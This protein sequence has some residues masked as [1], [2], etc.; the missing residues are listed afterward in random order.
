M[1]SKLLIYFFP[2]VLVMFLIYG[3]STQDSPDRDQAANVIATNT[4]EQFNSTIGT[5]PLDASSAVLYSQ[6]ELISNPGGGF[7]GANASAITDPGT[8]FGFGNQLLNGN[9]MADDFTVPAGET[10]IIDSIIVFHYQTGSTTTSTI[11]N[12][13]LRIW[14]G[15]TPGTGTV[16]AGDS[17]TN[18][19]G[20]SYFSG[21]YRVTATTLTNNQRPIMRSQV[22]MNGA[23]LTG[24]T[25]W[26]DYVAGGTLASGP[27]NPPRTIPGQPVTG[28]AYQRLGTTF[29]WAPALDG[30][31]PQG[32]P[33]VIYG[34]VS[35]PPVGGNTLVLM[36]DS[37]ASTTQ[38]T[39][40]RD[41]LRRYLQ[42]FV[43]NYTVA[44]FTATSNLP[45]LTPY[46]TIILQETSFDAAAVRYL[47]PAG[48]AA[49]KAW[50]ASGTASS[51]KSLISIGADQ[52]YNYSRVGSP[53]IDLEFSDTYGKYIFRVD[54]APGATLPS[55]TGVTIDIGNMRNL[56][57][58]PPG[59]SYWPDGCSMSSGG[60]SLYKYQNRSAADT[61]AAIGNNATG[62][63]VATLFCD[64]RYFTGG[65]KD[66][67]GSIVGWVRANGG[68]ITG[69]GNTVAVNIPNEY[70]L[71]QNY[72]NPFNPT[73]KIDYTIPKSGFVSLKI[74]DMLG[75][76]VM[77]LVNGVIDAGSHQA[78]FNG[79][80]LSS[81]TYFYRIETS[82]F[83]ATKKMSLLK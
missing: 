79:S 49:V 33:F 42:G 7:G 67:F 29:A 41:T 81:G 44:T 1:K 51:K 77:T 35:T 6:Q 65:F 12:I 13:N 37:T 80:N 76:E 60:I 54:N 66:V 46:N 3:Y 27:W 73:T 32:T 52:G 58:S 59:G 78:V 56:T 16:V 39:A 24:G 10:W 61:L 55:V 64:P 57:S 5:T 17:T 72:P 82:D 48:V 18:R 31:N 14:D 71:S 74:Y 22:N 63:V 62:Y 40:D 25:Y 70:T 15:S 45:D 50:L 8:L 68:L 2:I 11:N 23:S 4:I 34:S 38:R 53:A 30:T 75:K 28:N 21:I 26:I 36:H 83:V 69:T 19:L 43:G 47:S 9:R 20:A